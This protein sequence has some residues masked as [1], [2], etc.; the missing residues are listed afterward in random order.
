VTGETRMDVTRDKPPSN[1]VSV[2]L[3]K[4]RVP[5][6]IDSGAC[7][8]CLSHDFALKIGAKITPVSEQ[9]P[10]NL[11]SADGVPLRV[12][13][14]T[15][16][17]VGLKGLLVPHMFVVIKDLN[18]KALVGMGF[19]QQTGC[20]LDTKANVTSFYDDLVMLPLFGKSTGQAVLRTISRL[21]VPALTEAIM[22]VSVP[23]HFK[24]NCGIIETRAT[25][26]VCCS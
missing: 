13:G 21:V 26:S 7:V 10:E 24:P 16:A 18:H 23:C 6:L 1:L 25:T 22:R 17:T 4:R 11:L 15:E 19:L 14:Q 8:S 20:K 3:N 2:T 9:V 12:V 5:L